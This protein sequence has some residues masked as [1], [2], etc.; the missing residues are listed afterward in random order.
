MLRVLRVHKLEIALGRNLSRF[1]LRFNNN[2]DFIGRM[3]ISFLERFSSF[4]FD[5]D[6]KESGMLEIQFSVSSNT[7]KCERVNIRL[8]NNF[9]LIP[10]IF[11][12]FKVLGKLVKI[13]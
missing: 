12:F 13:G 4:K 10:I 8:S 2:K 5:R 6:S 9:S 11:K 7:T 1:P 3:L